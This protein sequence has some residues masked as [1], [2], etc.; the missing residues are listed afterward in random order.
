MKRNPPAILD[1]LPE[2]RERYLEESR[3]ERLSG[4]RECREGALDRKYIRMAMLSLREL[5]L[6]RGARM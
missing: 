4:C 2:L 1:R 5:R 6:A 3:R